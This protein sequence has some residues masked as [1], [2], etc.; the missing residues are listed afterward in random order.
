MHTRSARDPHPDSSSML[1]GMLK[2]WSK[3][4][5][6]WS[7]H[8]DR[9][10]STHAPLSDQ[11]PLESVHVYAQE[12]TSTCICICMHIYTPIYPYTYASSIFPY[13]LIHIQYIFHMSLYIPTY[14]YIYIC[15][16][17]SYH[18]HHPQFISSSAHQLISLSAHQLISSSAHQL[19]IIIII[20]IHHRHQI[21]IIIILGVPS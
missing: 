12:H 16:F 8:P 6:M 5:S 18:D 20:I 19:I 10:H 7:H 9:I 21:I 11:A 17:S 3:L 2:L 15:I 14:P 4:W 13:S 1:E